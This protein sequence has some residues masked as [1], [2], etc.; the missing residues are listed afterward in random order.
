MVFWQLYATCLLSTTREYCATGG[1]CWIQQQH[2]VMACA[3]PIEWSN[4]H[5]NPPY[6]VI[7]SL[8]TCSSFLLLWSPLEFRSIWT[9]RSRSLSHAEL[10]DLLLPWRLTYDF[11]QWMRQS[12][13]FCIF[14]YNWNAVQVATGWECS[15]VVQIDFLQC[16]GML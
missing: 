16:L 15:Y 9:R 5:T 8:A 1:G 13:S 12:H 10:A 2:R 3:T 11:H 4:A 7:I 14:Q 6:C